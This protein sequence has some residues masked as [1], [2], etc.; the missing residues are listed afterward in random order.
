MRIKGRFRLRTR[1]SAIIVLG[2]TI[3]APGFRGFADTLVFNLLE[4]LR[5]LS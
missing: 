1:A 5:D 3:V 4:L 2:T